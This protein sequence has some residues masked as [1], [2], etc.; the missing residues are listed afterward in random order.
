MEPFSEPLFVI[1][2]DAPVA[3]SRTFRFMPVESTWT[4]LRP[5][6]V[7]V[8]DRSIPSSRRPASSLRAWIVGSTGSGAGRRMAVSLVRAKPA[9]SF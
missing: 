9:A 8:P 3:K 7:G 6:G 2:R 4:R 5:S 1:K